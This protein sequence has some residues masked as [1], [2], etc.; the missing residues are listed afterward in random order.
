[1]KALTVEQ[2]LGIVSRAGGALAAIDVARASVGK[3]MRHADLVTE[4]GEVATLCQEAIGGSNMGCAA[5]EVI[6]EAGERSNVEAG[7]ELVYAETPSA[8]CPKCQKPADQIGEDTMGRPY[9]FCANCGV[10]Y[11]AEVAS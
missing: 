11:Q 10:E 2:L 8:P 3:E 9:Y 4:L 5:D 1:M 7:E 6:L